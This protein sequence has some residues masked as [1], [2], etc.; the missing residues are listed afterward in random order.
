MIRHL[1]WP[2]VCQYWNRRFFIL[3]ESD[4]SYAEINGKI[5]MYFDKMWTLSEKFT[6]KNICFKMLQ[7]HSKCTFLWE[8]DK[9]TTLCSLTCCCF[10]FI[11]LTS[12]TIKELKYNF[13]LS[14]IS[15]ESLPFC[16]KILIFHTIFLWN[17]ISYHTEPTTQSLQVISMATE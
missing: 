5:P 9:N 8:T 1:G 7:L 2:P 16:I 11:F 10:Q 6:T 13:I 15:K 12:K 4:P 17:A 14:C 3:N